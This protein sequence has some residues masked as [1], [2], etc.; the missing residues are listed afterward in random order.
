[1]KRWMSWL[2]ALLPGVAWAGLV[3]GAPGGPVVL[4]PGTAS[5]DCVTTGTG[6]RTEYTLTGDTV[7]DWGRFLLP[8]G[9]ELVFSGGAGVVNLLGG[10][11]EH[12]IDGMV[13]A[14]GAVGFFADGAGLRVT[15][16]VTGTSVTLATLGTGD[17]AAFLAG[18]AYAMDATAAGLRVM[19]VDGAV[20]ATAGDVVVAGE[21][22]NVRG[23]ANI[24]AAGAVRLAGGRSVTVAADG[25]WRLGTG[26]T[27]GVVQHLGESRGGEVE[28]EAR[29]E[30]ANAGRIE[31]AR[32]F[33]EV[34]RGGKILNEGS[35]VIVG[36]VR[37]KGRYDNDGTVLGGDEGDAVVAANSSLLKLPDLKR[38]DGSTASRARELRK[39]V[40]MTASSDSQRDRAAAAQ[41]AKQPA[42]P[43]LRRLSFFGMRGGAPGQAAAQ[44]KPQR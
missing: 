37:V 42:A 38:P 2:W 24:E 10:T 16:R 4:T 5:W 31:G 13:T 11:R 6:T 35:G 30:V 26:G 29:Q 7:L 18:G 32:V 36:Q 17:A 1:M 28:I 44:E 33:L 25:R 23:G 43:L 3:P 14:D 21:F 9:D 15:G 8:A 34:G 20:T 39:D 12:R 27:T 41:L 19:T 22:V 40:P